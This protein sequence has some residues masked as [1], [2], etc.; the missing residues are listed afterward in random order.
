M[1]DV[2]AYVQSLGLVSQEDA[3]AFGNCVDGGRAL[4]TAV[5]GS[6]LGPT[7]ALRKGFAV[8]RHVGE[9]GHVAVKAQKKEKKS[10][11]EKREKKFQG[12][13]LRR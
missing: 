2:T 11:A 6:P 13:S 3:L 9:D 8:T 1:L 5:Q 4:L 7:L 10:R 12:G